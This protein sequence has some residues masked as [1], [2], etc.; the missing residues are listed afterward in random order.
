[1]PQV[2][3][4]PITLAFVRFLP[5]SDQV[6]S[7]PRALASL[8]PSFAGPMFIHS[9]GLSSNSTPL[10][11]S[12]PDPQTTLHYTH[13]LLPITTHYHGLHV[14]QVQSL[15]WLCAGS[16]KARCEELA[17][18]TPV[19]RLWGAPVSCSFGLLAGCGAMAPG[20][21]LCPQAGSF[22]EVLTRLSLCF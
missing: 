8:P 13:F 7:G 2:L 21:F 5:S 4:P 9:V 15:T 10:A 12:F 19:W 6:P 11:A 16:H 18:C 22:E 17:G 14:S 3:C 1:M 20:P